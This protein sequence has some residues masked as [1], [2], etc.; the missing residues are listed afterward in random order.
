LLKITS[1]LSGDWLNI[2]NSFSKKCKKNF[3]NL[4]W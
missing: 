1:H 4:R 3:S 2:K